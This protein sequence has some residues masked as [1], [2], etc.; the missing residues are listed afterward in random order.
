MGSVDESEHESRMEC[1]DELTWSLALCR[2]ACGQGH[3]DGTRSRYQKAQT[4]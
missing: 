4:V 3:L 2:Q 1:A